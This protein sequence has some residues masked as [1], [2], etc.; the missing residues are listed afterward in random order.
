MTDRPIFIVGA[1]RSGTTLLRLLL[2]AHPQLSVG[3]E[4]SFLKHVKEGATRAMGTDRSHKRQDGLAIGQHAI[5]AELAAAWARVLAAHAEAT[6]AARWGDKTPVHRYHGARIRRLFPGAQVVA[7]VRH[8][9]AVARSRARWGYE[10]EATLRD[11]GSTVRHHRAD[12]RRFGPRRFHLVRYEDLLTDPRRTMEGLLA[13]LDEPWDEAVLDHTA[14][15]EE[16]TMTDGGTVKSDPLDPQR[17][18]AWTTDVE[19]ATLGLL[20]DR[21]GEE[22]ALV[23]YAADQDDPVR[24][25]PANELTERAGPPDPMGAVARVVRQRGVVGSARRALEEVRT[26]GLAG[27]VRRWR[28]L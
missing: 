28:R 11:W 19:D 17:A 24:P 12:A 9:A 27:A 25:L 2:D 10:E 23:G 16:G 4:T 5:E 3:P 22:M 15:V 26:R 1:Q 21:I 8:P 6:G 7:M 20:E 13:F 14:G 18:L